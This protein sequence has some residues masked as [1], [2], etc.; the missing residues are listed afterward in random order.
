MKMLRR[1][2]ILP[3]L[4]WASSSFTAAA[5]DADATPGQTSVS[6]SAGFADPY[7]VSFQA[8]GDDLSAATLSSACGG[9]INAAPDVALNYTA[10]A[11]APLVISATSSGDA[12]L[13]LNA[14]NGAWY[15]SDDESGTDASLT[16]R[17]PESGRYAIWVGV[18]GGP[19]AVELRISNETEQ[20]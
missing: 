12:T 16:F 13:L 17:H 14:P 20:Q 6:L 5:Q 15:C 7:V 11:H 18:K 1:L 10:S 8:N 4:I 19:A 9:I 3:L 2:L